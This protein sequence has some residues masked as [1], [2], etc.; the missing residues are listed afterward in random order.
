ML[1][2]ERVSEHAACYSMYMCLYVVLILFKHCP[3]LDAHCCM[4]CHGDCAHSYMIPSLVAF[5]F[6][7]DPLE[8][9]Q[10]QRK[11]HGQT[12]RRPVLIGMVLGFCLLPGAGFLEKCMH[13]CI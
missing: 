3:S 8:S 5:A 10:P 4:P 9:S 11:Q 7:E 13:A 1:A 2:G 12:L 6:I